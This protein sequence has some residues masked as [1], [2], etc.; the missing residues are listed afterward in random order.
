MK[1]F[2]LTLNFLLLL[3]SVGQAGAA[4]IYD[5][6]TSTTHNG[7]WCSACNGNQYVVFDDFVLADTTSIGAIEWDAAYYAGTDTSSLITV[8]F[9]SGL[10][11]GLIS[12]STFIWSDVE[13]VIN[14]NSN[15]TFFADL[16]DFTLGAG[17]YYLSIQSYNHFMPQGGGDGAWQWASTDGVMYTRSDTF[18]PFRLHDGGQVPEPTT[19]ALMGLGIAGIG[20]ARKKKLS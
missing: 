5:N 19:L 20:F 15:S 14:S 8:S 4:V 13:S 16:A 9:W 10:N 11:T 18:I 3:L 2:I 1:R 17:T 6:G 12:S 7:G